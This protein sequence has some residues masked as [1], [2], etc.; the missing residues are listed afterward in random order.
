[1]DV[2][3]SR[4][5]LSTSLNTPVS[6]A[7]NSRLDQARPLDSKILTPRGWSSVDQIA[8]GDDV[9]NPEGGAAQVEAVSDTRRRGIYRVTFND[10]S[11][12]QCTGDQIWQI[13]LRNE[14][15]AP[16]RQ[17]STRQ[18]KPRVERLSRQA[19]PYIPLVA[20]ADFIAEGLP[21]DPY[22]LGSLLG[23]GG[24]T[25]RT[26]TFT[27]ADVE[28]I[29]L[30]QKGLPNGIEIRPRTGSGPHQYGV[31]QG[32]QGRTPSPLLKALRD[33]DLLG[34]GSHEK[35]VPDLY[36]FAGAD[37]RLA[38]LRGLMDT[39]GSASKGG[40][41]FGTT[42]PSLARD[43]QFLVQSLGGTTT[44]SEKPEGTY[45]H[46]DG[47]Q[48]PSKRYYTMYPALSPATNPF[49]MRRKAE[50]W[51]RSR[52]PS[53]RI[54]AV[55]YIGVQD[56]KAFTLGSDNGLYVTNDFIVMSCRVVAPTISAPIRRFAEHGVLTPVLDYLFEEGVTPELVS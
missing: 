28:Q 4:G 12:T 33:L 1:M 35:F 38:M 14:D 20:A 3:Q 53:R 42:S 15:S 48:R 52:E 44:I 45:N 13:R 6:P 40:A 29:A 46:R 16:W 47:S 43:V 7:F 23:D 37:T 25:G 19:R 30:V 2:F 18:V 56:A 10:K 8:V 11:S 50:E 39:D 31:S 51:S 36:K 49:L 32:L 54:K 34:L 55:D 9:I 27:S 22:V 17:V 24:F 21:L 26:V 5:D 41:F